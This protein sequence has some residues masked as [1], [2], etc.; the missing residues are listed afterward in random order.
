MIVMPNKYKYFKLIASINQI[1]FNKTLSTSNLFHNQNKIIDLI[2]YQTMQHTMFHTKSVTMKENDFKNHLTQISKDKS[3]D[4]EIN[5]PNRKPKLEQLLNIEE[6]MKLHLPKFLKEMH[7]YGLYTTDVI[8]E[9]FYYSDPP[10]KTIGTLSYAIELLKIR[11]KISV[12][13]SNA[14]IQILKITHDEDDGTVKIRWRLRGLRGMKI[15]TPWK[16]K[17]WDLGESIKSEA[18]WH[19]GFSILYIRGDGRIYKHILQRV[20]AQKDEVSTD[21]KKLINKL[22][23]LNVGT[24]L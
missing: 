21:K 23:K 24:T 20:I 3:N 2:N 22:S 7:P 5:D 8:F 13:F 6:R 15:L 4:S 11:W 14:V 12:K 17:I 18:E 1:N 9:N 10:K 16:I 19:D